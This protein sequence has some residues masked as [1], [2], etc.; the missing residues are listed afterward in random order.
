M[1][2]VNPRIYSAGDAW[3]TWEINESLDKELARDPKVKNVYYSYR[4]PLVHVIRKARDQGILVD[5]DNVKAGLQDLEVQR[6]DARALAQAAS[7]WPM[8]LGSPVQVSGALKGFFSGIKLKSVKADLLRALKTRLLKSGDDVPHLLDARLQFSE[9]E[10]VAKYLR[11]MQDQTE[12]HPHILPTQANGR[13]STTDPPLPGFPRKMAD[14][15]TPFPLVIKPFPHT[16]WIKFDL[17]AIEARIAAAYAGDQDD[18]EAFANGY[19]IHTITACTMIYNM[20]LPPDLHDPHTTPT[21]EAWRQSWSPPWNGKEDL[22]RQISKNTRYA[23]LY[24][25]DQSGKSILGQKDIERSGLD[26]DM[27]VHAARKYMARKRELWVY[28]LKMAQRSVRTGVAYSFLGHR[29]RLYGDDDMKKKLGWNTMVSS[30][31]SD[32]MNSFFIEIDRQFPTSRVIVNR[33][34]G[35]EIE[36]PNEIPCDVSLLALRKIV[37]RSW[38]INGNTFTSMADWKMVAA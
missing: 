27:L 3:A 18:L 16:Y 14:G 31:V 1:S 25:Y 24:S 4:L 11:M 7:G 35:A 15:K 32:M 26:R 29:R 22:R 6:A 5:Q 20:P 33:H 36:F 38:E 21:C 17:K 9:A 8:N 34:D 13:W 19:D 23:T 37:E 28:K 10:S 2:Y 30:S 12:V